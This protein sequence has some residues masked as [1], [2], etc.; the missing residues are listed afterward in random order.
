[1]E[2][3]SYTKQF[4]GEMS[5]SIRFTKE[6][7]IPDGNYAFIEFFCNDPYCDCKH[8]FMTVV[9]AATEKPLTTIVYGWEDKEFY[10]N[11]WREAY[12]EE[13][14]EE[15]LTHH[16]GPSLFKG[17]TSVP[18][19]GKLM[20]YF[21]KDMLDADFGE[22]LEARYLKFKNKLKKDEQ[23]E[24]TFDFLPGDVAPVLASE[25]RVVEKIG[26]NEPCPCGSGKKYKKCCGN[27]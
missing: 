12:H 23:K 7:G 13:P 21:Q 10:R 8:V 17:V 4:P 15:E 25:Q 16:K 24:K 26:R 11:W 20:E 3:S 6:K 14:T 27:F 1:M 2:Y 19:A 22:V 9:D 5:A 18:F